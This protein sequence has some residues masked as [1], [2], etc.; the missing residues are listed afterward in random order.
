MITTFIG[1]NIKVRQNWHEIHKNYFIK[2]Y[3]S[4]KSFFSINSLTIKVCLINYHCQIFAVFYI[5]GNSEF[6]KVTYR[7]Y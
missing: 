5:T 2:Y 1:A 4:V 3:G 6:R 7:D